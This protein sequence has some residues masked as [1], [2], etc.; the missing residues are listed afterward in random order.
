M[1]AVHHPW[2]AMRSLTG[3]PKDAKPE[4]AN[5]IG[6]VNERLWTTTAG[7]AAKAGGDNPET[8]IYAAH[9]YVTGARPGKSERR[10]TVTDDYATRASQIP[11]ADYAAFGH[12]H[13]PQI[14]E[15]SGCH[16][17]YAGSLIPLDFGEVE[18]TKQS[19]LVEIDD[20]WPRTTRVTELVVRSGRPLTDFR[21][22]LAE[23]Q[24]EASHG[25][26]NDHIVRAVVESD[27]RIYDLSNQLLQASPEA[28]VHEIVNQVQNVEAMAI[29]DYDYDPVAEPPMDELFIEWRK[30]RTSTE[31][32][33]DDTA[34]ALFN[35][36]LRNAQAPGT[37]DF[38]IGPLTDRAERVLET[39]GRLGTVEPESV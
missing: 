21:G 22:T 1:R 28:R 27:D 34:R 38:G 35:E 36:A 29:T 4:Y 5:Y 9:L 39:L 11:D 3:N 16:A 14:I 7:Q 18:Q 10:V 23:L 6:Q 8:L 12:I 19:C 33:N 17:R 15:G 32:D 25:K 24:A 13:D 31:R 26:W 30:T 37:S 20:D 2:E